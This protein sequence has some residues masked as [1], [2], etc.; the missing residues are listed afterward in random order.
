MS[1][2]LPTVR[3]EGRYPNSNGWPE[4]FSRSWTLQE[5]IAPSTVQFFNKDWQHI[6]D[7]RTLAHTLAD[8]THVPHY[9]LT[10]GISSNRPCVAQIMSWAADRTTTRVED[11]AYSLLGLLDANIPM[12]YGEGE[13]AFHRLQL[14]IIRMSN[15][16][17]IFA[18]SFNEDNGRTGSILADD[19]SFFRG[20][21][22]MELMDPNEFIRFLKRDILEEELPSIDKDQLGVFPITDRGIQFWLFL[23]PCADSDSVFAAWLPCRCGSSFPP[24]V[25]SLAS[26]KTNY[27][28]YFSSLCGRF[29]IA[30][31]PQFRQLYLR[32]QD[33]P[34]HNAI[35]EIEDDAIVESGLTY[36]GTFPSKLSGNVLTLTSSDPLCIKVYSD[37]QSGCR[38]A[39]GIGQCFGQDWI[40]FVSE[41]PAS[42]CP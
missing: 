33:T 25:I 6:G 26:W 19:P 4:W 20:C 24:V 14:E 41:V 9:I 7:K 12:V 32:Y 13:K 10:D 21:H 17:S 22:Q 29:P 34:H 38:F 18:W 3:D 27:Y 40:H 31:T 2:A 15:D 37:S 1:A 30:R 35:F 39:V 23:H 11:K 8:I 36:C 42:G 28:R 5:M 16:Q